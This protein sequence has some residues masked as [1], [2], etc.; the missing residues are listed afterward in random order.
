MLS[1]R[2]WERRKFSSVV[3]G[4]GTTKTYCLVITRY[5]SC[6]I[7]LFIFLFSNFFYINTFYW[8]LAIQQ[9]P[10]GTEMADIQN[11]D[12]KNTKCSIKLNKNIIKST[13]T[14][15]FNSFPISQNIEYSPHTAWLHSQTQQK[16]VSDSSIYSYEYAI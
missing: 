7:Y 14:K 11:T 1:L 10:E 2:V 6:F 3:E 16:A 5:W 12:T 15:C 13:H 4:E 8:Q 9:Q